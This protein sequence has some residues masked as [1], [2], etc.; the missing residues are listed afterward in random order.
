M[1]N[2]ILCD[3]DPV[4]I[5]YMKTMILDE[6]SMKNNSTF[7]EFHSGEE[8]LEKLDRKKEYHLLILDMQ[9]RMLGGHEVAKRFR[10]EFPDVILVF[11]SGVCKPTVESFEVTPFRYL[12]KE[13]TKERLQQEIEVILQQM[14]SK[15]TIPLLAGYSHNHIVKLKPDD[16]LYI[17]VAKRGS[18]VYLYGRSDSHDNIVVSC[19]EKVSELYNTY[20]EHGF[21]YAH[22][23]YIVNLKYITKI[24]ST[25]LELINGTRLSI[26]RSKVKEFRT[27]F[28]DYMSNKYN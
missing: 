4:F 12:L 15:R 25:E 10:K 6:K 8:L 26:A 28:I 27:A 1:Y 11:C 24:T 17:A 13:Y 7:F 18:T 22:N 14:K 21:G 3:D 23:S 20:Q 2:I 5:G 19:R 9:M 16:I